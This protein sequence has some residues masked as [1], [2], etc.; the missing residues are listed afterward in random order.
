VED[1]RV[2]AKLGTVAG[3]RHE[4][5]A[6]ADSG[7]STRKEWGGNG[8]ILARGKRP[9]ANRPQVFN[10]PH[11]ILGLIAFPMNPALP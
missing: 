11:K 6:D 10:L 9:I 4:N 5:A 3:R 7:N 2:D 8:K 1:C